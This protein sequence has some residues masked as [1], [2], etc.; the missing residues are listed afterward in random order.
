MKS[1]QELKQYYQNELTTDLK[2]VD[3]MRKRIVTKVFALMALLLV[4]A[5]AALFGITQVIDTEGFQIYGWYVLISLV[6]IAIA[7]VLY[8]DVTG[9]KRFHIIFKT[10]VIEQIVRF[11]NPNF[12]YISH[13]FIPPNMFV[14]SK[15]FTDLPTKYK[16][17]DY[18]FGDLGTTKIAF[19][20]VHAKR[21]EK[22]GEKKSEL[23]NIFDGIFFVAMTNQKFTGTIILPKNQPFEPEKLG[24]TSQQYEEVLHPDPEFNTYFKVYTASKQDARESFDVYR[25]VFEDLVSYQKTHKDEIYVSFIGSNIYVAISH[26]KELFEPRLYTSLLDFKIIQEYYDVMYEPMVIFEKI[27]MV[28]TNMSKAN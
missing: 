22:K 25:E 17:D 4:A 11:I 20:E 7:F 1:L 8:Y 13:K 16:G 27:G 26:K 15:L 19:S 12:T 28:D 9:D 3:G 10:R 6:F 5:V 21:K 18:V 14:D 23:K 2:K 24:L